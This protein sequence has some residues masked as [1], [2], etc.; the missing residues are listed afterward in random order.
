M[1]IIGGRGKGGKLLRKVYFLDLVSMTWVQ[2]DSTTDT[3]LGRQ[4]HAA[5]LVGR[6]IVIHGGWDGKKDFDDL[7]VLDTDTAAWI[8]PK[9]SGVP[10]SARHGHSIDLSPDGRLLVFGG[11]TLKVSG[12]AVPKYNADMRELDI[13]SMIWS[14]SRS[15]LQIAVS[16]VLLFLFPPFISINYICASQC[17]SNHNLLILCLYKSFPLHVFTALG[18]YPCGR[19]AH[20]TTTFDDRVFIY[21][22]WTGLSRCRLCNVVLPQEG[23]KKDPASVHQPDCITGKSLVGAEKLNPGPSQFLKVLDT[24][25]R[26][27]LLHHFFDVS[28]F[29]HTNTTA[30]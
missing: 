19:F 11:Y 22:G 21:G 8:K 24:K 10:P 20:S 17:F 6:K 9:V 23:S 29:S 13:E 5:C 28:F 30:N 25:V 14:R 4:D 26:L 18:D 7:W 16:D 27:F 15:K 2:V 12:G 3:P 1:F